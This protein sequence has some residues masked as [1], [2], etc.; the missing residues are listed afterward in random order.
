MPTETI[1]L[2]FDVD[3]VLVDPRAYKI[4]IIRTIEVLCAEIGIADASNLVPSSSEIAYMES[5]G[6]HDV[7]DISNIMF[8]LLLD[9]AYQSLFNT[10]KHALS[11]K[12]TSS[13]LQEIKHA[14]PRVI[15]PD[16]NK[17]ADQITAKDGHPP[18]HALQ[19]LGAK[20]KD[21]TCNE[22]GSLLQDFL[23]GT[24]SVYESYGTR[25]FQN[26]ILGSSEFET[27]YELRSHYDGPSLLKKED[28]VLLHKQLA[29]KLL[30]LQ[31]SNALNIAVYT[32]RPSHPPPDAGHI[33]G[34]SPEAE[35]AAEAAGLQSLPLVGMGMMEWLAAQHGE[36]TEDL[37]KPN[38][39][40]SISALLAAL[41][42]DNSSAIL[43]LAYEIDKHTL[44]KSLDAIQADQIR[45]YVFE[46]TI[47]GI[48]PMKLM[49]NK[50]S[51]NGREITVIPLGIAEDVAKVSALKES[52]HT[53]FPNINEAVS[54]V[55]AELNI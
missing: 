19:M 24:R 5:R 52:C 47:S 42:R 51:T 41:S 7:W 54:F 48:K 35:M 28:R 31:K 33:K 43:N 18:D 17:F 11:A 9:S 12:D 23:K 39:T 20:L 38:T 8:S 10:S 53:V 55:L 25:L 30:A 13:K 27:T 44:N 29:E 2:L 21:D 3:G 49:G 26:I 46:D 36:R 40:H 16:Y 15:R 37:T 32:A 4:G 50:L 1:V 34:Y 14:G 45:I 6:I 22:W